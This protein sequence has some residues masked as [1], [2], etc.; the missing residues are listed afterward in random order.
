MI[1]NPPRECE[2]RILY[3]ARKEGIPLKK[4]NWWKIIFIVIVLIILCL[5]FGDSFSSIQKEISDTAGQ[6]LLGIC[7]C[8][9]FYNLSEG[10]V[11]VWLARRHQN[12]FHYRDG[13]ACSYYTAFY[14]TVTLGS[15]TAA[16]TVYFLFKKGIQVP[17]GVAICAVQYVLQRIAVAVFGGLGFFFCCAYMNSWFGEYRMELILGYGL[18]AVI[19]L[20]LILA[21]VSGRFHRTLAWLGRKADRKH[22]Y[23][24]KIMQME[25]KGMLL[26]Q[27][28]VNLIKDRRDI[29]LVLLMELAKLGCW[30]VI[31]YMILHPAGSGIFETACVTS[32]ILM[33]AGIIPA[34]GGLGSTEGVFIL[35]FSRIAGGVEAASAMLLY[36]F[37]TYM[38]PCALGGIC[39]IIFHKYWK[40]NGDKG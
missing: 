30:Y 37:A 5:L 3:S 15:G 23:E 13:I 11:Y 4:N 1:Q 27:E 33:L 10:L 7:L 28:T 16:A 35:L 6:T 39:V 9:V 21:C 29:I 19:C 31:P 18:T 22:K 36:R 26:R 17:E 8:G 32:L 20:V 24:N 25:G 12:D 40:A 2:E 38:V 34:P 14:R